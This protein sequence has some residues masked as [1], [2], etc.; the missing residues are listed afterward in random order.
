MI[1]LK[2]HLRN[3]MP[4]AEA[5]IDFAGM[6]VGVIAGDNGAGK[7]ALLDAITWALWSRA[8]TKRDD[9]LVRQGAGEMSVA[10]TFGLGGSVYQVIRARKAGKRGAGTLDVQVFAPHPA[11]P[12]H[13][14]GGAEGGE[15]RTLAEPTIHQT[16]EKI[17]SLLK[18]DYDTFINSAFLLQGRADEFTVK[19]PTE[20]KKVLA[21]ILGLDAWETYEESAK[22]RI[23]A[24]EAGMQAVDVRLREIDE[25]IAR[26]PQVEAEVV[27]ARKAVIELGDALHQVEARYQQT[28]Q[29]QQ[30]LRHLETQ[31]AELASRAR[32]AER[33]LIAVLTDL[34]SARRKADASAIRSELDTTRAE[35][36]RLAEREAQRDEARARRGALAEESAALKGQND[37]LGPETE[38]LKQRA[39]VLEASTEPNCPTC[40]QALSPGHRHA[41]ISDLKAEIEN[42]RELYRNNQQRLKLLTADIAA[43]D[44]DLAALDAELRGQASLQRREAE[45]NAALL[46]ADE[47][48]Q[49][50]A[51]LETRREQWQKTL[52]TDAL[53]QAELAAQVAALRA[54]LGDVAAVQAEYERIRFEEARARQT[55]GAAEQKLAA[56]EAMVSIREG[57]I[58]ERN[59]LAEEKGIYEELRL[60]FGKKG[61]P[62]MIIEAAIPEIEDEANALLS[63]MTSGRMNLRFDTQKETQK[64]DTVETLDIQIADELGTRPYE[65]YSGGEQFRVN[66][67][68]RVA[69]SKLLARR[70][71]AQLQTLVID[72]GFGALDASGRERLV[73]AINAVQSDFER[74]LV[75]THLDEL[76]DAFPARIDV[77][78]TESGSQ[79]VVQ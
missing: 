25:D 24:I 75:I 52:D 31:A 36:A 9:E 5:A 21:D 10:F 28:Q 4:Y 14:G 13:A 33:E 51:R 43:L 3:F 20:R 49:A 6:H 32:L 18:L 16:Q 39:D 61:V 29:A 26:R 77:T 45:L 71:G 42:R 57:K 69:L 60:A 46:A 65:N 12:P 7:S 58:A 62:A 59:R 63:R 47:A 66:F 55:L 23:R 50:I 22:Q 73:E 64:G 78:K 34:E 37:R 19:T 56:C 40:G 30:E 54:D 41:V 8:R 17:N 27:E 48:R 44:R 72:E 35:L 15:W 70:A 53:K 11:L 1:P 2:L 79:I 68:V 74:I 67:A 76:K 38:P